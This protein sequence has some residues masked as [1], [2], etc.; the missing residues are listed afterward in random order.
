MAVASAVSV[1]PIL[2]SD[3]PQWAALWQAYLTF[4]ET[5]LPAEVYDATFRRI[6]SGADGL[7]GFLATEGDRALGLVHFL[8]H[9]TFW[10]SGPT[11][12]LQDLFTVPDARGK[13]V[14]RALMEAVFA[15]ASDMGIADVYWLTAENNYRGRELYDQVGTRTPFIVY[16]R[17]N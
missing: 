8:S 6:L 14:A 10:K 9:A 17:M 1:R 12:Y 13:G 3:R 7:Y 5:E 2:A 16:E 4:Y 15:K 11:C